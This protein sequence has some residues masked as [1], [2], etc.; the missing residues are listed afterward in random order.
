MPPSP[1]SPL[2]TIPT[3]SNQRWRVFRIEL[4]PPLAFALCVGLIAFL[5]RG[6][7]VAP[8]LTAEAE[9][10]QAELRSAL[11]GTVL[12]LDVEPMSEVRAGDARLKR[13]ETVEESSIST[14]DRGLDESVNRFLV[15]TVVVGPAG[16]DF[17]L[18]NRLQHV[19]LQSLDE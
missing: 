19:R 3:P 18:S 1:L 4:L 17:R 9:L 13:E 10:A 16:V 6:T 12:A 7:A 8:A 15:W 2:P 11:G 14:I 5:W